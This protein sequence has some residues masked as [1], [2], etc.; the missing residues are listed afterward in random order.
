MNVRVWIASAAV[1]AAPAVTMAQPTPCAVGTLKDYIALGARGCLMGRV[2]F[3]NF[4]FVP[5]YP[6]VRPE[7][8][9]VRS[10]PNTMTVGGSLK[11]SAPWRA[12]AGQRIQTAIRYRAFLQSTGPGQRGVAG[13][14]L[15]PD[16]IFGTTGAVRVDEVTPVGYLVVLD[17]H[18]ATTVIRRDAQIQFTPPSAMGLVENR[19]TVVGG[20]QGAALTYFA[21]SF[22]ILGPT[23]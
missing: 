10:F 4:S 17:S 15:G 18:E 19:V 11:F 8:I 7:Q 22:G 16:R 5:A 1:L 2:T 20:D 9:E 21:A 12:A 13:L 14:H 23:F 6:I 3:S